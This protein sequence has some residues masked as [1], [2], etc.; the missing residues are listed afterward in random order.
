MSVWGYARVSTAQGKQKVDRQV[1]EIEPLVTTK[2]HLIIE[3]QSGK[4]FD[5]PKYQ[6]MKNLMHE[7]DTLVVKSLD[8]LGRNY[9]MIKEEWKWFSD[10]GIKMKVLDIPLLDSEN[11][12]D[13]LNGRFITN[14]VLEILSYVAENER[15]NIH[16]R[17]A[18]GIAAAKLKGKKFGRHKLD[19]PQNWDEVYK[20]WLNYEITGEEAFK[21]LNISKS[22]F[23]KMADEKDI[24][25]R[26]KKRKKK[27]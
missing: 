14:L 20:K 8:R 3:M 23:Y 2:D 25:K 13:D 19:K 15:K 12:P 11:F 17:Q 22:S 6:S 21:E 24:N 16:Q 5:R 9:D 10:N 27:K 1:N 4:D 7:G 18:E 26:K